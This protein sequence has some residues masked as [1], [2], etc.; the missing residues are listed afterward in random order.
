MKSKNLYLKVIKLCIII[1]LIIVIGFILKNNFYNIYEGAET[2]EDKQQKLQEIVNS[3]TTDIRS[4]LNNI[5][6]KKTLESEEFTRN[7][8]AEYRMVEDS[9]EEDDVDG[10]NDLLNELKNRINNSIND[11]ELN[12]PTF[13][14]RGTF[15]DIENINE[16]KIKGLINS[17]L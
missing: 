15:I 10:R 16:N 17:Y 12:E 2:L 4:K 7:L 6:N 8:I 1:F 5:I 14:T 3:F 9:I 11:F 13:V